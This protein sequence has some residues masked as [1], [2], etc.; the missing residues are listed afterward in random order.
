MYSIRL[1]W[2]LRAKL[3]GW[4]PSELEQQMEYR[5]NPNWSLNHVYAPF[6]EVRLLATLR[7]VFNISYC[8]LNYVISLIIFI[9]FTYCN[10]AAKVTNWIRMIISSINDVQSQSLWWNL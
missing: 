7:T 4:C 9:T 5:R 3:R 6:A 8:T 2:F 10:C 1:T